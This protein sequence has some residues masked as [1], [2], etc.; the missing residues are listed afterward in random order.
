MHGIALLQTHGTAE[1]VHQRRCHGNDCIEYGLHVR[2]RACDY[3][4]DLARRCLLFECLGELRI[5]R[6]QCR[7]LLL[8]FLERPRVLDG[9]HGLIGESL[10]QSNLFVS[11]R[12]HIH[13]TDQDCAERNTLFHQRCCQGGPETE[14][15]L[16]GFRVREFGFQ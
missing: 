16:V 15:L 8:H 7:V 10:E 1:T 3:F 5:G 14:L 9:D 13:V 2:R 12:F 4:Q 11:E 6:V